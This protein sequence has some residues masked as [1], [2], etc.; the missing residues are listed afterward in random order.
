MGAIRLSEC[1]IEMAKLVASK[2]NHTDRERGWSDKVGEDASRHLDEIGA[3]GEFAFC[4]LHNCWPDL[5]WFDARPFDCVLGKHT[6]DVKCTRYPRTLRV[7]RKRHEHYADIF[8]CMY[9]IDESIYEFLGWQWGSEV[10]TERNESTYKNKPV[11]NYPV[12]NLR[13]VLDL[14]SIR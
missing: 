8:V 13:P 11:W 4:K 14:V 1:E 2:R 6:I 9:Q 7:H 5:Q 12:V 3:L 10:L